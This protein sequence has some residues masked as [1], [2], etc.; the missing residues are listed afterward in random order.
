[1]LREVYLLTPGSVGD[2]G[3]D[4][5]HADFAR[6]RTS[7]EKLLKLDP[8]SI[9]TRVPRSWYVWSYEHVLPV[10]YKALG[11]DNTGIGMGTNY[12]VDPDHP[13]IN[14]QTGQPPADLDLHRRIA[15]VEARANFVP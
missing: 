13:V 4:A 14:P 9:R 5:L 7:C 11:S 1:M 10:V 8:L 2:A 12:V 6:R 3:D 15:L